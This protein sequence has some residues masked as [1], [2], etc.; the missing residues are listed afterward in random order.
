MVISGQSLVYWRINTDK[1]NS[2]WDKN[3]QRIKS[4]EGREEVKKNNVNTYWLML[5]L[6]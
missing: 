3:K 2:E 5:V 1:S 4:F 6:K